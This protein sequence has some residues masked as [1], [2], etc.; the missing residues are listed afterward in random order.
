MDTRDL[1][2]VVAGPLFL[3]VLC[4][5]ARGQP[6]G[7]ESYYLYLGQHPDDAEP[8]WVDN[9]QG[10]TTD[11]AAHWYITQEQKI[12]KIP[13]VYDLN[14]VSEDDPNVVTRTLQSVAILWDLGYEH[15]GDLTYYEANGQGYLAIPAEDT[16]NSHGADPAI[17]FFA[18]DNLAYVTRMELPEQGAAG[19]VA[20]DPLGNLYT[21]DSNPG[22]DDTDPVLLRYELDWDVLEAPPP[23]VDYESLELVFV[24]DQNDELLPLWALQGGVFSSSG[25]LLYLSS[26]YMVGWDCGGHDVPVWWMRSYCGIHVFDTY[27][28]Q[29]IEQSTNGYGYFNYEFHPAMPYCQE[30]EGITIWDLDGGPAPNVSGQLHVFV[31][32]N[33]AASADD[34]WFKHYTHTISVDGSYSGDENGTPQH[35]FNTVGEAYDFAWEGARLG[36]GAGSYPEALTLSKRVELTAWGGIATVGSSRGAP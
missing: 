25:E 8:A 19:W 6:Q 22:F 15:I 1:K 13:V 35:P 9:V 3:I 17:A 26:G 18:A 11:G 24:F 16:D 14:L 7:Y 20:I 5:P 2:R 28:W 12:W 32:E 34:V 29:R 21:A 31:L 36:I 30:A 10:V 33:D 27:T 23:V 4:C